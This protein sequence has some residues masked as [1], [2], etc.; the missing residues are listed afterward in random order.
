M[1]RACPGPAAAGALSAAIASS[2]TLRF[3]LG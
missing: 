2:N 1:S 3:A